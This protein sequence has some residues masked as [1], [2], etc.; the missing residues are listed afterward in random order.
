MKFQVLDILPNLTNPVTGRQVRA[1]ERY[2]QALT[3]ARYAEEF[4]YDAVAL[5]ERHAGPFLSSGV[6]VLLGAI[7]ATTSRVRIQ[8]GVSVLSIHDP[9]RVAEDYATVDQ[10]SRG[11]LELV[12]GKGNQQQQLP[13]FGI[14][15][16]D[17]WESLQEKYELLRRLWRE[18]DV[19]WQGRFR[20]PLNGVT[21]LPRPFAGA[22][23]IWHGPATTLTSAELAAKWGDPLFSANAIQPRDNYTV[24]IDHYRAKYAEHGHDPRFAYVAAGAGFLYLADTTQEAREAF[25]PTYE[26]IVEFFNLP[27]N[28][29]PGNEMTFATIDDAIERGPVLVGSPQ[30]IA[31]KILWFHEGFGHALQSFSLPTMIPHEQQ[32]HM[33]ERLASE[34]IPVVR[35]AAPTTLWSAEDPY[36]GRPAVHGRTTADAASEV[37]KTQ[38][39]S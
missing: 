4:G 11:R 27:G 13:M 18:E 24:L 36:G 21:S 38:T 39:A 19:T 29:T 17:Q 28:H 26:K 20:G 6:S 35:A 5:G 32:L 15:D 1:D 14:E 23:R 9:L 30:Q 16:G 33:L 22:P 10:L 2:A 25:G 34:V 31:E 37:E 12:V 7:A 3:S 8:T